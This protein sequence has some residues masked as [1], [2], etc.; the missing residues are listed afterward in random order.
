MVSLR[1]T[2]HPNPDLCPCSHSASPSNTPGVRPRLFSSLGINCQCLY[3]L[4]AGHVSLPV[5]E[6]SGFEYDGHNSS[7]LPRHQAP[8]YAVQL[9]Q[10]RL[11]YAASFC[12]WSIRNVTNS[13]VL[14]VVMVNVTADGL[15][16]LLTLKVAGTETCGCPVLNVAATLLR[17]TQ[18]TQ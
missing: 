14:I 17:I 5:A 7:L 8:G 11:A 1:T 10:L 6:V 9:L 2:P 12:S 13:P 3:T 4:L 18:P 16:G 15:S